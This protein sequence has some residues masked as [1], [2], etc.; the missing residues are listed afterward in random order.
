MSAMI[1]LEV[2]FWGFYWGIFLSSDFCKWNTHKSRSRSEICD[3]KP[4][5]IAISWSV[6]I[7]FR[8]FIFDWRLHI[9]LANRLKMKASFSKWIRVS[10]KKN[11]C[12]S[13]CVWNRA[14]SYQVSVT[15]LEKGLN[16]VSIGQTPFLLTQEKATSFNWTSSAINI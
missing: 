6:P 2:P 8:F 10:P 16:V 4:L 12:F 13:F 15:L 9:L 5:Y 14:F 11:G 3:V 1:F 7:F